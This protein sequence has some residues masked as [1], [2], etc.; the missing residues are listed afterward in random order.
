MEK[1]KH[2]PEVLKD[3]RSK[4]KAERRK[5]LKKLVV[6]EAILKPKFEEGLK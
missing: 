2:Q 5:E 4:D 1:K 6:Y 3:L